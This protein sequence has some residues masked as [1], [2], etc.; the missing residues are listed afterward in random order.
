MYMYI[1]ISCHMNNKKIIKQDTPCQTMY[2]SAIN[3]T[4]K[5]MFDMLQEI[6]PNGVKCML[7][8]EP[9]ITVTETTAESEP[10]TDSTTS[11]YCVV[12]FKSTLLAVKALLGL[13]SNG[14]LFDAAFGPPKEP[15]L[16]GAIDE[17]HTSLIEGL[18][19]VST[20]QS[21]ASSCEDESKD[22]YSGPSQSQNQINVSVDISVYSNADEQD[23]S[24][25]WDSKPCRTYWLVVDDT[26]IVGYQKLHHVPSFT[27]RLQVFDLLVFSFS[28][29]YFIDISILFTRVY[30]IYIYIYI[31]TQIYVYLYP[32][33][34][35]KL[36]YDK[37]AHGR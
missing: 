28:F 4:E 11:G 20:S 6:A 15:D 5:K 35:R 8:D 33:N 13:Y 27:L 37:Q 23:L 31:Y 7:Y 19:Q 25:E 30:I 36:N 32:Y 3:V 9:A 24:L 16:T 18:L 22:K 29:I 21:M 2:F 17:Y 10:S 1:F 14:V 12:Q 26:T 34:Q